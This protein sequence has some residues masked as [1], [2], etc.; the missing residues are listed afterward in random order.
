M[1]GL[2]GDVSNELLEVE[3]DPGIVTEGVIE[4]ASDEDITGL[5]EV[6]SDST[7][8]VSFGNVKA[9]IVTEVVVDDLDEDFVTE[10]TVDNGE[11]DVDTELVD[12]VVGTLV[13]DIKEDDLAVVVVVSACN[14]IFNS[15]AK[16]TP[17]LLTLA[18]ACEASQMEIPPKEAPP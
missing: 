17:L 1:A 18:N 10:V 16:L 8:V 4:V 13:D 6:V 14:N 12:K 7:E 2:E 3:L 9:E 11:E 5:F 15:C